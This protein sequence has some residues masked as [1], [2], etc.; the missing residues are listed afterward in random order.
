MYIFLKQKTKN[1]KQKTKNKNKKSVHGRTPRQRSSEPVDYEQIKLVKESL[2]IP[3]VANGDVFSLKQADE[4]HERT[5]CDGIMA[6]R[7][8]LENPALFDERYFETTPK[9]CIKE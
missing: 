8:L 4:V 6:A 9:Q 3:L 7:G 2:N 1:K 5:G